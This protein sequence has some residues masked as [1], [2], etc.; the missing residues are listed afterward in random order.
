MSDTP[1][2]MR[3]LTF[4]V[5]QLAYMLLYARFSE[6]PRRPMEAVKTELLR[7]LMEEWHRQQ[8]EREP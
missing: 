2:G 7:G 6:V 4:T 5:E 3:I 1:D 8:G